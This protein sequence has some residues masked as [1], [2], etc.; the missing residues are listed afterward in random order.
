MVSMRASELI[1][2]GC[3]QTAAE[4]HIAR[5][6]KRLEH[7]TRY[8]PVHVRALFLGAVAPETDAGYLYSAENEIRGEGRALLQALDID[9][10]GL[11]VEAALG[12]FQ[13]RGYLLTYV[14]ECPLNR[15]T[16]LKLGELLEARIPLAIRRIRRSYQPK[17]LVLLGE[18]LDSFQAKLAREELQAELILAERLRAF[19]PGELTPGSLVMRVNPAGG[20]SL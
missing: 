9:A 6:L 10:A 4:E 5:R 15:G 14:L 17:R 12:E 18:E 20:A 19:R 1:C 8:R 16:A 3:G 11:S 7:M 13:R 2:D